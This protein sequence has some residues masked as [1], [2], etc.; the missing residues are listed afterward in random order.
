MGAAFFCA[1][2]IGCVLTL[3]AVFG[4]GVVAVWEG[5][6]SPLAIVAK[7]AGF[8]ADG[9]PAANESPLRTQ[10]A[11]LVLFGH[12]T[13][14]AVVSML[15]LVARVTER[16]TGWQLLENVPGYHSKLA[17]YKIAVLLFLKLGVVP[18]LAGWM[19]DVASLDLMGGTWE[20]RLAFTA[21]HPASSLWAHWLV[22]ITFIL[23]VTGLVLQLREALH[24]RILAPYIRAHDPNQA[25]LRTVMK[26]STVSQL[27][28]TALSLVIFLIVLGLFVWLPA[29]VAGALFPS[30][31]GP[32]PL[33]LHYTNTP[34]QLP[35]DLGVVHLSVLLALES[36]KSFTWWAQTS[37]L[38]F[39]CVAFGVGDVML[40][41]EVVEIT[42]DAPA[43][44]EAGE[45]G[46]AGGGGEAD[47]A[48]A[49]AGDGGAGDGG[50]GGAA[51]AAS[52]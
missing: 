14:A 33:N 23:I 32:L 5:E 41:E 7:A 50:D 20:A 22:G 34:L 25:I 42:G 35:L 30:L 31:D 1:V 8:V 17:V 36:F 37:W 26:D 39:V 45:A 15:A 24:P 13:I 52:T 40:P 2:F 27:N 11:G 48:A 46:D 28:R 12:V 21:A 9:V 43:R 6:A 49:A 16:V 29:R 44:H 47:V 3:P 4:R 38:D 51:S 19:V 18:L 10:E